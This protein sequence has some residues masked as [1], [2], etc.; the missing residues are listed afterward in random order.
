[1]PFEPGKTCIRKLRATYAGRDTHALESHLRRVLSAMNLHPAGLPPRAIVCIRVLRDPLPGSLRLDQRETRPPPAWER[2]LGASLDKLVRSAVRPA[3][4]AVPASAEA[5][6]FMDRSEFLACLANDSCEGSAITRWWWQGLF[7]LTEISQAVLR[8]WLDQPEYIPAALSRLAE[9]KKVTQFIKSL[10][11]AEARS[12]LEAL[13]RTFALVELK[14]ALAL[15]LNHNHESNSARRSGEQHSMR[16]EAAPWRRW[17]AESESAAHLEQACLLAVGL[18]L[19]RAPAIVRSPSFAR[20]VSEWHQATD[21]LQAVTTENE[22]FMKASAAPKTEDR[23][24]AAGL[25]LATED[26]RADSPPDLLAKSPAPTADE[27]RSP[28]PL[29]EPE[30]RSE[31]S[32]EIDVKEQVA[33]VE[34]P[35]VAQMS[36]APLESADAPVELAEQ[37]IAPTEMKSP[38]EQA[39]EVVTLFEAQIETDQG[40]VFYL[41]NLGLFL[42]LYGDFTTPAQP[43]IELPIWDFIALIG[44]QLSGKKLQRDPV[45]SLLAQ[46]VGRS[47]RQEPGEGFQPPDIW[48]VPADWPVPRREAVN[49]FERQDESLCESDLKRWIDWL[50]PYVRARLREA[51][52]LSETSDLSRVLLD[53]H[54]RA[55]VTATHLDVFFSLDEL[56]V[57]I[58]LSGLDRDPG[59]VPAA[60][61]FIAFHFE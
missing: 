42:N 7:K 3:L 6:L 53:H 50:M 60:G 49:A 41:I 18:M 47:E 34:S 24:S 44:R 29:S 30:A 51:L 55:L 48:R 31:I 39:Q 61:R 5:V 23:L 38:I 2:A 45:W 9:S 11:A 27:K 35:R 46:L 22:F 12:M 32:N 14:P 36:L 16:H 20:A 59:W 43:G 26:S 15:V 13:T 37:L 33:G 56:P 17:V 8:E 25:R 58:R 4:G 28:A 10:S 57:E 19:E 1:M 21:N 54:A 52:G 40:G